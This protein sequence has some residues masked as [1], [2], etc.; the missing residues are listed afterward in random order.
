MLDI[1]DEYGILKRVHDE[2]EYYETRDIKRLC[3]NLNANTAM[4]L[5]VGEMLQEISRRT[6]RKLKVK[7]GG[8]PQIVVPPE[9][10]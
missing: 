6:G 3:K 9:K 10:M 2:G 8:V 7:M 4:L 1:C 5:A